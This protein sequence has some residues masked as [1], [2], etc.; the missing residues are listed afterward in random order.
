MLGGRALL[1][2]ADPWVGVPLGPGQVEAAA[3]G[4]GPG[5]LHE[6][7]GRRVVLV[8]SLRHDGPVTCHRQTAA[9]C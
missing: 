9:S 3:A 8:P 2:D 6:A 1:D 7:H 5:H 4:A